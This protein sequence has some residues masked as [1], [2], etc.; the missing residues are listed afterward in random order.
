MD[1]GGNIT[2][3]VWYFTVELI[4]TDPDNISVPSYTGLDKS[5]FVITPVYTITGINTGVTLSMTNGSC[6]ING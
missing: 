6:R 4:D 3:G 2:T 5:T 1:W